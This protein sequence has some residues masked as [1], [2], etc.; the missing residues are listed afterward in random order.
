MDLPKVLILNQPFIYNTGGGITLSNLFS[1]WDKNKLAVACS[2]YI[3]S[4]EVDTNLCDNY[5]QLGHKERKWI[6][7]FNILGRKYYS[8]PIKF[9]GEPLKELVENKSKLR[10]TIIMDYVY[11]ALDYFGFSH[12]ITKTDLSDQFC[13]WLDEFNP[14]I[15]YAQANTREH[16][17]F[18]TKVYDYLKKPLV[19]H[20]M[21]DWPSTIGQNGL[22]KKYWQ[23]KINREFKILFD[24][25][26]LLMGIS[27]YMGQEYKRRYGKDF[28][29]FHNPINIDFW[30]R[31]QR[32]NYEIYNTPKILYAGRM[33]LGIDQSL[34]LIARAIEKV[35]VD[36]NISAKFILQTP[37]KPNWV[38]KY[39][40]V[41]YRNFVP[42][43][44]LP[45]VFSEADFLI[46]P[47][48]FSLKSIS[49]I[50]YSMPTKAPEYM[51]SG[52]PIII[53]APKDTAVVQYAQMHSWASVVTNENI[54]KLIN[55][56]KKLILNPSLRQE[57]ATSAKSIAETRHDAR[58]VS[59]DFQ[60]ALM[61]VVSRFEYSEE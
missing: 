34:E 36:L 32:N 35:N 48:D 52:T 23:K 42:Y 60:R 45:K 7:P 19:F 21:D 59:M 14:D 4:S 49:Y 15:I 24:K 18:C 13:K 38:N 53:F 50:K 9:D 40:D 1:G 55:T 26:S 58:V 16:V 6:F 30:E 20:M 12:F 56:L 2:G 17:N 27:D 41:E 29:T 39:K 28:L 57:I 61:N 54:I 25:A 5:Y 44:D 8:G 3:L 33:G 37:E 11:P 46:L 10:T 47:Y 31:Y 22:F 51:A 43:E